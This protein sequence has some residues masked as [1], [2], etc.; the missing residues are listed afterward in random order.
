[1]PLG[2]P[3]FDRDGTL[4]GLSEDGYLY[5]I[6]RQGHERE[7]VFLGLATQMWPCDDDTFKRQ[8]GRVGFAHKMHAVEEQPSSAR[9]RRPR[10]VSVGTYERVLP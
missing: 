10:E 7:R 4:Y 5:A 1:V 2:S 9:V 6:D 3:A 8:R